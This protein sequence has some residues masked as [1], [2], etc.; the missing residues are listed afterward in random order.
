MILDPELQ[1]AFDRMEGLWQ[2]IRKRVDPYVPTFGDLLDRMLAL[3]KR[4]AHCEAVATA[5]QRIDLVEWEGRLAYYYVGD[6]SYN[7]LPG[8]AIKNVE[9]TPEKANAYRAGGGVPPASILAGIIGHY[10]GQK[11]PFTFIDVGANAGTVVIDAAKTIRRGGLEPRAVA[12]EPGFYRHLLPYNLELN[13]LETAVTAESLA[14]GDYDGLALMTSKFGE[15]VDN[16][17]GRRD[18][19][20]EWQRWIARV[21]T[22]DSYCRLHEISGHLIVKIDTQGYDWKVIQGAA[23]LRR[24]RFVSMQFEFTPW[25][26]RP[27]CDPVQVLNSLMATDWVFDCGPHAKNPPV[28]VTDPKAACT[29]V[30]QSPEYWT[31]MLAI[32]RGL[33]GGSR[34]V[35]SILGKA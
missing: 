27:H 8:E 32:P 19:A 20:E 17:I 12:F 25:V 34:L 28:L 30:D 15:S 4:V 2:H 26:L 18:S 16:R 6:A 7:L 29:R 24:D 14:V 31:D 9:L 3:E 21:V 1:E 5:H 22:L 13:G 35:E 33:P 23:G 11:L 10:A